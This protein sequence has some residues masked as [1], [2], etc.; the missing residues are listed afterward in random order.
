M[1]AARAIAT[2]AVLGPVALVISV[3]GWAG[4]QV[5]LLVTWP[6]R[7]RAQLRASRAIV[8]HAITVATAQASAW[9]AADQHLTSPIIPTQRSAS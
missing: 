1:R 7:A 9:T 6:W 8:A 4:L 5:L 3:S 2:L